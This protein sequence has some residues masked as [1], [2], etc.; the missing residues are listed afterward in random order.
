VADYL[1]S[2]AAQY[3]PS[4]SEWKPHDTIVYWVDDMLM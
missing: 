1:K 4:G 2:C 3:E